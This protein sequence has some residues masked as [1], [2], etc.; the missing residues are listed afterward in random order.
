MNWGYRKCVAIMV[1]SKL[2]LATSRSLAN[3]SDRNN[4]IK[5]RLFEWGNKRKLSA[6]STIGPLR[7]MK[8]HYFAIR[9]SIDGRHSF[10]RLIH[11][12]FVVCHPFDASHSFAC[13]SLH[14]SPFHRH[15]P[16]ICFLPFIC[17]LSFLHI[18][19]QRSLLEWLDTCR[20]F[21][22]TLWHL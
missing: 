5:D 9:H 7:E 13:F 4:A 6:I 18:F 8:R 16:L 3:I 15:F 14:H 22:V 2:E 21:S 20:W 10:A 11:H 1:G 17:C 12:S 19:V